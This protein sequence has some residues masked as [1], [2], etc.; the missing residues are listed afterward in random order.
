VQVARLPKKYHEHIG[1]HEAHPGDGKS[2]RAVKLRAEL[3]VEE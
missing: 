2:R 3:E 1:H